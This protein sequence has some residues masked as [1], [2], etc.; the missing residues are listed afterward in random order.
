MVVFSKLR[1]D[2]DFLRYIFGGRVYKHRSGFVWVLAKYT[3]LRDLYDKMEDHDAF[4][5]QLKENLR[6]TGRAWERPLTAEDVKNRR[7]GA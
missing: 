5:K 3:L 2:A 7:E 6:K 4:Q 1:T